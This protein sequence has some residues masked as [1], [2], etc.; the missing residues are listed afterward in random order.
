MHA[1]DEFAKRLATVVDRRTL[2]RRTAHAIFFVAATSA[3]GQAVDV[4]AAVRAIA[5]P[6]CVSQPSGYCPPC[7]TGQGCGTGNSAI[8][9]CGPS[10]CCDSF[11]GGCN[12]STSSGGCMNDGNHCHGN[13]GTWGGASCWS[14]T[15]PCIRCRVGTC[16]YTTTCRDCATTGCSYSGCGGSGCSGS[17]SR[18]IAYKI[19]LTSPC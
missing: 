3:A 5:D 2:F 6:A 11:S 12:C 9:P 17:C 18:C 14:C 16:Q 4:F 15:G 10:K 7:Q 8:L 13:A 19:T 1:A